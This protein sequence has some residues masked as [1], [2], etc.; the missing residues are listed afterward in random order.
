MLPPDAYD[1][2]SLTDWIEATMLVENRTHMPRAR[3]RKYVA[4]VASEEAD[5]AVDTIMKEVAR[6]RR[7]CPTG[8]PFAHD[9]SGIRYA[10][11][12]QAMPYVFMLA[13]S[14]SRPYRDKRRYAETDALFDDMVL[15]ALQ[16]YAGAG[17]VGRRFA[18]RASG[19]RPPNFRDAITWL[20]REMRLPQGRGSARPTAGD[21]GLDVVVWR[22]FRDG[23]S[24]FLAI[25]AQC[26]VQ[27]DW[28][29]KAR[30]LARDVWRGW[31]DFG[32]DPHLVLAVPFVIPTSYPKWDELRRTVHTVLD[33]LRLCELLESATSA[34]HSELGKW[35][36]KEI[37]AMT[38]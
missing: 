5:L 27:V 28:F 32:M 38:P 33:R 11:A 3:L 22:P 15:A 20:S 31:I 36:A 25:L 8:Y 24:G 14:T 37:K 12:A 21:G 35:A 1:E 16:Q 4:S 18:A 29:G 26:T 2:V 6:R 30:D 23:R 10:T 7:C 17:S 9:E 13:V 34:S 19:G